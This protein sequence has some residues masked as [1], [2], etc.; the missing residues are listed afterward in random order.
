MEENSGGALS[1]ELFRML[2]EQVSEGVW[3]LDMQGRVLWRNRAVRTL[4]GDRECGFLDAVFAGDRPGIDAIYRRFLETGAV[5]PPVEYRIG[6]A[7]ERWVWVR[8]YPLVCPGTGQQL[9]A[10][11]GTDV[12]EKKSEASRLQARL[13]FEESV[14]A[15]ARLLLRAD[16]DRDEV[17]QEVFWLLQRATGVSR[18]YLFENYAGGGGELLMRQTVEACAPGVAPQIGNPELQQVPYSGGFEVWRDRLSARERIQSLVRD[19]PAE[20]RE[21]LEPQEIKSL[22]VLPVFC[23]ERWFGFIGFDDTESERIWLDEEVVLLE[24]AAD[25]IGGWISR[26]QYAS[27][28][29]LAQAAIE[30]SSSAIT[31]SDTGSGLVYV[32]RAAL[33]LWGFRSSEEMLQ[34]DV[35]DLWSPESRERA[36]AIRTRVMETGE[37][38][39]YGDLT[40]QRR[41]GSL[42]QVAYSAVLVRDGSGEVTGLTASWRDITG[43]IADRQALLTARD[44]AEA[45]SRAKTQFL[46]NLSHEIRTPM[47]GII[48]FAGMALELELQDEAKEYLTLVEDSARELLSLIEDIIDYSRLESG[49]LELQ[50]VRFAVREPF[51]KLVRLLGMNSKERDLRVELLID[52]QVPDFLICDEKRLRQIAVNLLGNAFK[53]TREGAVGL[54]VRFLRAKSQLVMF[55]YD[56][57]IGIRG[58]D[59]ERAFRVFEQLD[60]SITREYGGTGMGLSISQQL[61]SLMG[62]QL[63]IRS[64]P[65]CGTCLRVS[66][67]VKC[68]AE[69]RSIQDAGQGSR[70]RIALVFPAD[71]IRES[72]ATALMRDGN[73]VDAFKSAGEVDSGVSGNGSYQLFLYDGCL[74]PGAL[75]QLF[76]VKERLPE[77]QHALPLRLLP[78][79]RRLADPLR[80]DRYGEVLIYPVLLEEVYR[81]AARDGVS[82]DT[83]QQAAPVRI[84]VAEDEEINR[85]LYRLQL[86]RAGMQVSEAADGETAWAMLQQQRFDLLLLDLHM[87]AMSGEEILRRRTELPDSN[88]PVVVIT[89]N[90]LPGEEAKCR[91]L[92][93]DGYAVKPVGNRELLQLLRSVLAVRGK[94]LPGTAPA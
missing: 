77:L 28:L 21:V 8:H 67:P 4:W 60:G 38:E 56:S 72:L 80:K 84:L 2:A 89:A 55:F 9:L 92:G 47:N 33:K 42:F 32:N 65:G 83:V 6:S 15:S 7:G 45:A 63:Q 23:G 39:G 58:E 76:S 50:E 59:L 86:E 26:L 13:H 49:N 17:L 31:M 12:T 82:G 91:A 41:D 46:A 36:V 35:R 43:E 44:A 53:F 30:N 11:I 19:L 75:E 93:A 64:R 14:A 51:I 27:R 52:P 29:Q 70:Y 79:N 1:P 94:R 34:C 10:G 57:G 54:R 68:E 69:S 87:P 20:Q 5:P 22:L 18:V 88:L 74:E 73:T 90:A 81:A 40:G 85:S 16:Q 3:I 71:R 78:P 61:V 48:G 24:T 66:V 25:I 37:A 62:G